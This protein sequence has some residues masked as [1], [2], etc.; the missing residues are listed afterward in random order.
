MM[1]LTKMHR[2]QMLMM[3][4]WGRFKVNDA[5][6]NLIVQLEKCLAVFLFASN[7]Y[8]FIYL[9]VMKCQNLL[10]IFQNLVPTGF[11]AARQRR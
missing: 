9:Y 3:V 5:I 6:L 1:H 4:S 10:K 8:K 2:I 11:A 7:N